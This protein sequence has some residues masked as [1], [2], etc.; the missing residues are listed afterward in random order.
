MDKVNQNFSQNKNSH[1]YF[2]LRKWSSAIVGY[3][4][5][6]TLIIFVNSNNLKIESKL[7]TYT[8]FLTVIMSTFDQYYLT[9]KRIKRV[10]TEYFL[11]NLK[12]LEVDRTI[13]RP[14][15]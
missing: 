7:I 5:V 15:D 8:R 1:P 13:G 9:P 14:R 10:D 4:S 12:K 11:A 2:G 3:T 6:F